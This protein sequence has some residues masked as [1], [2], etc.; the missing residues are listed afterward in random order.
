MNNRL[1]QL[2]DRWSVARAAYPW[3][4]VAATFAENG[5]IWGGYGIPERI[6]DQGEIEKAADDLFDACL[7]ALASDPSGGTWCSSGRLMVKVDGEAVTIETE[8]LDGPGRGRGL[9]R[10]DDDLDEASP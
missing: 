5:W 7:H 3:A 6:P 10:N 8:A 2:R 1:E 9:T 4:D